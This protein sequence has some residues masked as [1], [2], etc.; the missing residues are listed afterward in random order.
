MI[1]DQV[2]PEVLGAVYRGH[3]R[4][5]GMSSA[6]CARFVAFSCSNLPKEVQLKTHVQE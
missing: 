5:I 6:R 2:N 4:S 3:R 1:A